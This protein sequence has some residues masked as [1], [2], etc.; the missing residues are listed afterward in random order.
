MEWEQENKNIV[1]WAGYYN[2]IGLNC[3]PL[4]KADKKPAVEWGKYQK[5]RFPKAAWLSDQILGKGYNIGVVCGDTS[6]GLVVLDFDDLQLYEK[7]VKEIPALAEYPTARTKKGRHVYIRIEGG[8]VFKKINYKGLDI[9]AN[10][11]YVVAP[12]SQHPQRDDNGNKIFYAWERWNWE[13]PELSKKEWKAIYLKLVELFNFELKEEAIFKSRSAGDK[14]IPKVKAATIDKKELNEEQKKKIKQLLG[15]I[16]EEGQ[17]DLVIQY[18]AG[19]LRKAGIELEE[20]KKILLGLAEEKGDEEISARRIVIE[21]TYKIDISKV[22]GWKGL[23]ELISNSQY[24]D[25]IEAGLT[26]IIPYRHLFTAEYAP[27]YGRHV[28]ADYK[29]MSIYVGSMSEKGALVYER[30]V[31]D[32]V[33]EQIKVINDR[34]T[35]E[36]QIS[37]AWRSKKR[38]TLEIIGTAEGIKTQLTNNGFVMAKNLASDVL[39]ILISAMV[40]RGEAEIQNITSKAGYYVHEGELIHIA[41]AQPEIAYSEAEIKEQ[42]N[43]LHMLITKIYSHIPHKAITVVKWFL[44]APFS[45]VYKK[46][47]KKRF[48]WLYL[49][50]ASFTGKSTLAH[51]GL[52]LWGMNNAEHERSFSSIDT[53]A[54]LGHVLASGTYPTVIDETGDMWEKV[55]IIDIIKNSIDSEIARGRFYEGVYQIIPALSALAFTSNERPPNNPAIHNRLIQLPFYYSDR[56]STYRSELFNISDYFMP[57]IGAVVGNIL[58]DM[59]NEGEWERRNWEEIITIALERA[60]MLYAGNVPEWVY[61]PL[62][63]EHVNTED[64]TAEK[65]RIWLINYINNLYARHVREQIDEITPENTISTKIIKLAAGGMIPFIHMTRSNNIYINTAALV[66]IINSDVRAALISNEENLKQLLMGQI[67]G[68]EYS[69]RKIG[70]R[71]RRVLICTIDEIINY[72]IPPI[73]E[74]KEDPNTEKLTE[75]GEGE[76]DL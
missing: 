68:A 19:W 54:R 9:L 1:V 2:N 27:M 38:E 57:A 56:I 67:N 24:K 26:E 74:V 50:G 46:E 47:F 8:K 5:E 65:I 28:I 52:G 55:N 12:P 7:A 61:A 15:L 62:Y 45:Y 16:Y 34:I 10:G 48:R 29:D 63:E 35:G 14:I 43:K 51:I 64:N 11:T 20:A 53:P 33:P 44:Y 60:Y 30:L 32:G 13:I 17:R 70:G 4:R 3:I 22:K 71:S 23:E 6:G 76:A 49:Y 37:V 21:R 69:P 72:L 36:T 41:P 75:Y 18:A 25:M 39:N 42:L 40:R 59:Y 31:F 58:I 73:E 66:E